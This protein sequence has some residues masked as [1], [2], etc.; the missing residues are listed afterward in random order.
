VWVNITSAR[1]LH[2]TLFYDLPTTATAPTYQLDRLSVNFKRLYTRWAARQSSDRADDD[3]LVFRVSPYNAVGNDAAAAASQLL[4]HS[5]PQAAPSIPTPLSRRLSPLHSMKRSRAAGALYIVNKM[6][7][8]VVFS[9]FPCGTKD[10]YS[11]LSRHW[12]VTGHSS[13]NPS[14]TFRIDPSEK[15]G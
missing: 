15:V 7:V 6:C 14:R 10:T 11:Q 5:L 3:R 12:S 8:D 1:N 9:I 2:D 4:K 13:I